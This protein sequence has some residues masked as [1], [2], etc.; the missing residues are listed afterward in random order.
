[1]NS[2]NYLYT[3]TYVSGCQCSEACPNYIGSALD[4]WPAHRRSWYNVLA[5]AEMPSIQSDVQFPLCLKMYYISHP[6]SVSGYT[7]AG[8]TLLQHCGQLLFHC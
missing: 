8:A 1:M 4:Y 3:Y 5:Q 2:G 6:V 7:D